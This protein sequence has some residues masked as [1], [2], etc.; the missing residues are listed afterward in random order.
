MELKAPESRLLLNAPAPL[1]GLCNL[2][3]RP[4]ALAHQRPRVPVQHQSLRNHA[5][6]GKLSEFSFS[7]HSHA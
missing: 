4:I 7:V 5:H 6:K 3:D 1:A 2:A